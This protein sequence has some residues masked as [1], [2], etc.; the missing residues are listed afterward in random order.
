[1]SHALWQSWSQQGRK[2]VSNIVGIPIEGVIPITNHLESFNGI[3]KG[4]HIT[5]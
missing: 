1:M 3:L 4:K 2:Q 5:R